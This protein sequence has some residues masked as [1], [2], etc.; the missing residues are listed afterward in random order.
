MDEQNRK[1]GHTICCILILS[2]L[3]FLSSCSLMPVAREMGN[4]A[5]VRTIAV[6]SGMGEQWEITLSTGEQGR[7]ST[8]LS[9]SILQGEGNSLSQTLQ[10][11]EKKA[12]SYVFYGYIDQLLVGQGVVKL[13]HILDF[14]AK[15]QDFSL[16]TAIWMAEGTGGKLMAESTE[17]RLSTLLEESHLN[18]AGITKTVG[19]LLADIK[20][21]KASYI[22]ILALKNDEIVEIGYTII[23]EGEVVVELK[24]TLADGLELL[25][26]HCGG[27]LYKLPIEGD[28]IA[29]LTQVTTTWIPHYR[30]GELDSITCSLDINANIAE[31]TQAIEEA[32]L[33]EFAKLLE[34]KVESRA[35]NTIDILQ[36]YHC[37][38]VDIGGKISLK[39]PMHLKD[40]EQN[41]KTDFAD[42]EIKVEGC[43][44]LE[45]RS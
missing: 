8:E 11:I 36:S 22:P 25:E 45:V 14:F 30:N 6:D 39:S 17:K 35:K 41:W 15:N 31:T 16:G 2:A 40:L 28:V 34:I 32:D 18:Q 27:Q 20:D 9:P 21:Q 13:T 26:G 38:A 37:D 12:H 24:A 3:F 44:N 7:T 5:L 29:E 33:K 23:D 1:I 10:E 19:D 4:M 43:I 42:V